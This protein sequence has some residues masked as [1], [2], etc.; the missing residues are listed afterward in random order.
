MTLHW[1]VLINMFL[2]ADS[3]EMEEMVFLIQLKVACT[4]TLC[5]AGIL[6]NARDKGTTLPW[7]SYHLEGRQKYTQAQWDV[8]NVMIEM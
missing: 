8:L 7:E 6:S 3:W 1:G 2:L 5:Q 4:V